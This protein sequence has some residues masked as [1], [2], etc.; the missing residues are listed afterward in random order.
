MS[1]SLKIFKCLLPNSAHLQAAVLNRPIFCCAEWRRSNSIAT[2]S[3][4]LKAERSKIF[5]VFA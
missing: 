5:S 4:E 2:R 1:T 3:P